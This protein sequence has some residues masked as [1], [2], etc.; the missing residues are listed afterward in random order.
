MSLRCKK[1]EILVSED[2]Q[3]LNKIMRSKV[4]E[5]DN[6]RQFGSMASTRM[7][8]G[9]LGKSFN[10]SKT[11]TANV[12]DQA[13][14]SP[15]GALK[16]GRFSDFMSSDAPAFYTESNLHS[17]MFTLAD[18]YMFKTQEKAAEPENGRFSEVLTT[19]AHRKL[20]H[21]PR[22][23]ELNL[24]HEKKPESIQFTKGQMAI[25]SIFPGSHLKSPTS[26]Q[27][28][29]RPLPSDYSHKPE[30]KDSARRMDSQ[31]RKALSGADLP[32][33]TSEGILPNSYHKKNYGELKIQENGS[34][35]LDFWKKNLKVL[36]NKEC[37]IIEN[38]ETRK[39]DLYNRKNLPS[40]YHKH[41]MFAYETTSYLSKN[42]RPKSTQFNTIVKD[43]RI[44]TDELKRA[45]ES[46][47]KEGQK[48]H[49][50]SQIRTSSTTNGAKSFS[51]FLSRDSLYV[52]NSK[53]QGAH[54][55]LFTN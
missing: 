51:G 38:L 34:V 1:S 8:M 36:I 9:P 39:S 48:N 31:G 5:D 54:K 49:P 13:V 4:E 33:I 24:L 10:S 23:I 52:H 19:S 45:L 17:K 11:N 27:R 35:L 3:R 15:N 2:F 47:S 55:I 46:L 30:I 53:L 16:E 43:T 20:T 6:S 12:Q 44:G 50:Q 18:S 25:S 32:L 28:P 41:Y 26:S 37:I 22:K 7:T 21:K 40:K 42:S 29:V 14:V